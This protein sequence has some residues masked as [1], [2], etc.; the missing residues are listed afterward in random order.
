M[1]KKYFA[2]KKKNQNL[3]WE[4]FTVQPV[5]INTIDAGPVLQGFLG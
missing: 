5:V 2:N 4:R 3:I 1:T